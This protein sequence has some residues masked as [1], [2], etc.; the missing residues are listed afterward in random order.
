[1][2]GSKGLSCPYLHLFPRQLVNWGYQKYALDLDV[3]D[4]L[5]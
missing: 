5:A 2:A 3:G 4:Y 1:M